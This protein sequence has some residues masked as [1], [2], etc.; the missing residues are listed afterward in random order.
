MTTVVKTLSQSNRVAQ[1]V[2]LLVG[3]LVLVAAGSFVLSTD[4][5][6]PGP[7][8]FDQTTDTGIAAEDRQAFLAEGLSIPEAQVFYSQY[9]FVV[10]YTGVE[11]AVTALQQDGHEQQFGYPIAV[12]VSDFSA[13]DVTLTDDGYLNT[14]TEPPWTDATDAAFVIDSEARTPTGET[15]V[16]F[17]SESDAERFAA[18]YGGDV[19]EWATLQRHSFDIDDATVVRDRVSDQHAAADQY[20]A[21]AREL[22][23]REPELVVGEDGETV[24]ETLDAA[25]TNA[26]V[27]V[28]A[29]T[30][31]ET[32]NIN[33][34]VTLLGENATIRGDGNGSVIES[35]GE[36]VAIRGVSIT[37]VGDSLD[38]SDASTPDAGDEPIDEADDPTD[39]V[40]EPIDESD[41]PDPEESE[42]DWDATVALAYGYADAGI[43]ADETTTLYVADV[44]IDTPA[45]AI[46][47]RDVNQT[48]I[49]NATVNGADE[50]LDGMMGIMSVRSPVIM[51]DSTVTGGRDGIYLHRAP[52][53]VVRN[54]TFLDN[55]F[56]THYMYT[57]DS[58][59]ANNTLRGQDSGAVTIMTDS[60]RNAVVGND[61]RD[62]ATGITPSGSRSYIAENVV[63]NTRTAIA[64][65]ASNSLY[66]R[67]VVYGNEVGFAASSLQPTSRVTSNDIVN[68]DQ[69]AAT[70]TG[71]LYLWSHDGVG[72]YWGETTIA[73]GTYTPT[74][75]IQGNQHRVGGTTVLANSPAATLLDSFRD[76]TPGMREATVMDTAPRSEPVQPDL[77]AAIRGETDD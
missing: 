75:P 26:T 45:S 35:T 69:Q 52:E 32:L 73:Q 49:E 28:P 65:A 39:G 16:P 66:E 23:S 76:T 42:D 61:M 36:Q 14:T 53:S 4:G 21:D 7:V 74:D 64:T 10:G 56:G 11:H 47:L 57:S 9:R 71:P 5:A 30:Y 3:V 18:E 55:R 37:G 40:D 54:N 13:T 29:G 24:Q 31:N 41:V 63:V 25:P 77:L 8:P 19:V 1:A 62:A 44:T 33:R 27:R 6:T 15:A 38:G 22:L 2:V 72:N 51:Q 59:T 48:V 68:N 34:S 58:L 50:W 17:E 67:N 43:L 60:T 46:L 12:Y 70:T 20:V